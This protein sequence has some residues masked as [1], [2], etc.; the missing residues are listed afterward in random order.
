VRG[1]DN[2]AAEGT[3]RELVDALAKD[4]AD[5][6]LLQRTALFC[7]AHPAP[8]PLSPL[9]VSSSFP[10]SPSLFLASPAAPVS[11]VWAQ[12]K[13]FARLFSALRGF[14]QPEKVRV[15]TRMRLGWG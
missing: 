12:D 6:A 7:A 11:G 3:L 13:N 1:L 9:S 14:L 2:G 15:C 4:T 10:G 8:D 5:A